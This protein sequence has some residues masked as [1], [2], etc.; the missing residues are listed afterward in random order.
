MHFTCANSKRIWI[1]GLCQKSEAP[2]ALK[3]FY[4]HKVIR[5]G[6][7]WKHFRFD[8]GGELNT[9]P[10]C[11]WL[12]SIGV[13]YH[14]SPADT[15]ELNGLAEHTSKIISAGIRVLLISSCMDTVF[16]FDAATT[17]VMLHNILPTITT[18]GWM[19]PYQYEF[20]VPFN[21]T[22]LRVW[23]CKAFVRKPRQQMRK[24]T[25]PNAF[26]GNLIGYSSNPTGWIIWGR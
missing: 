16:S 4:E 1:T 15:P 18:A 12:D 23:G 5:C 26:E 6:Y 11:D 13:S 21:V 25:S 14:T 19:S 8:G 7:K 22:Y 24:D 3:E 20:G 10:V 17:A 2:N 9:K